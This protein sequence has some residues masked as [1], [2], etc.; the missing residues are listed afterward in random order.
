MKNTSML[1]FDYEHFFNAIGDLLCITDANGQLLR[2]NQ[3]WN[4][5]PGVS[6][7]RLLGKALSSVI[8]PDDHR[9]LIAL[10]GTVKTGLPT[11][12]IVVLMNFGISDN[13]MIEW[14]ATPLN[15]SIFWISRDITSDLL[16]KGKM[17]EVI[18]AEEE[19]LKMQPEEVNFQK[20]S[21]QLLK[22]SG[23]KYVIV[24][25]YKDEGNCYNTVA[26]SGVKSSIRKASALLGFPFVGKTWPNDPIR[27]ERTRNAGITQYDDLMQFAGHALP[28]MVV[29]LLINTFK[30]GEIFWAKIEK[31]G[32]V[33][34]DF[35]MIM[36]GN[37]VFKH[38]DL[39][40]IYTRQIGLLL[41]RHLAELELRKS[42]EKYRT[43]VEQIDEVIFVMSKDGIILYISPSVE[44]LSGYSPD[45]Y[46]NKS[47]TQFVV[48]D[49]YEQLNAAFSDL[50]SGIT[51]PSEFRVFTRNGLE[52]WVRSSSKM[53]HNSSD[54]RGFRGV[55]QNI[56]RQKS[57]EQLLKEALR[58]AE[59]GNRLKSAF[60]N[61]ISH[62]V[63]TP[64]NGILGFGELIT[65]PD[66]TPE[67]KA[68]YLKI[69]N[70]SGKRLL[71]TINDYMDVSLISS[72]NMEV[73]TSLFN[74]N[75]FLVNIKLSFLPDAQSKSINVQ[76]SRT[77]YL[78][79]FLIETDRELLRKVLS[80]LLE[81]AIKYS[82]GGKVEL[83][84]RVNVESVE[85]FVRDEGIGIG[86]EKLEGIFD[87]FMQEDISLSRKYDG[88]GLG[89]T[90]ASGLVKLLGGNIWVESEKGKG[91]TFSFTIEH[92]LIKQ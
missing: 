46:I 37:E 70:S 10:L 45:H 65:E 3:A 2:L 32:V 7:T 20:I 89:L 62:E 54:I 75:D 83:G 49:D 60:L 78:N 43:L 69:L 1:S 34:G 39:V 23:A 63:R 47:F 44:Q 30:I 31:D 74:L 86:S 27:Y 42:E 48:P 15:D 91:S 24:N 40:E 16:H 33:L 28:S 68:T 38:L 11:E 87:S 8:H 12:P 19:F 84:Y 13:R 22:I 35:T 9:K 79:N 72:G 14:R 77:E 82:S 29:K 71:E 64:L 52:C 76:I 4:D 81:N 57:D 80:Q 73:R 85:F 92:E 18:L 67:T 21:D 88:I 26:V 56:T 59:A 17:Q 61:N 58:K 25:I 51:Y 41:T 53:I 5:I 90:I 55:I 6:M 50:R 36:Q 66:L